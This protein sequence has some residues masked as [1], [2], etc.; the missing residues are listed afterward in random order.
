MT[1]LLNVHAGKWHNETLF[2]LVNICWYE[3]WRQ[4]LKKEKYTFTNVLWSLWVSV[5]WFIT[6]FSIHSCTKW[7]T[8][9]RYSHTSIQCVSRC[10]TSFT[11]FAHLVSTAL[12]NWPI[13]IAQIILFQFQKTFDLWESHFFIFSEKKKIKNKERKKKNL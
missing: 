13:F 2:F 12:S 4:K 10:F 8:S 7:W 5:T 3:K 11:P 9:L 6:V 1:E